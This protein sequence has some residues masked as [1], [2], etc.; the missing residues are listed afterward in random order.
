[1]EAS[2]F[3]LGLKRLKAYWLL[4]GAK[5]SLSCFDHP[6][7]EGYKMFCG[8]EGAGRFS[9]A[10]LTRR[11]A[12]CDKRGGLL[13]PPFALASL[14]SE[15]RLDLPTSRKGTCPWCFHKKEVWGTRA[16]FPE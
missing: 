6:K 9:G 7:W 8:A 10:S 4:K 16:S 5:R 12:A 1:M 3:G 15:E 11:N 13:E 14:S 2:R